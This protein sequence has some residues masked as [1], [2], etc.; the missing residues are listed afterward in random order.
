MR[1]AYCPPSGA[2]PHCQ[3]GLLKATPK[4][5]HPRR[6]L[7]KEGNP[8]SPLG[9]MFSVSG[10]KNLWGA[11]VNLHGLVGLLPSYSRAAGTQTT[12]GA[13]GGSQRMLTVAWAGRSYQPTRANGAASFQ[14][15]LTSNDQEVTVNGFCRVDGERRR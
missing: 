14:A 3:L 8:L 13:G 12:F 15:P 7:F 4:N 11:K 10:L 2:A 5:L 6:R 9:D 1:M